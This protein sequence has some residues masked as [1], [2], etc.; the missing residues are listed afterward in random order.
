MLLFGSPAAG[1]ACA[2]HRPAHASG[3]VSSRPPGTAGAA[4]EFLNGLQALSADDAWAV[5]SSCLPRCGRHASS[6]RTLIEHWNGASW[7]VVASPDPSPAFSVLTAVAASSAG[8]AWAVGSYCRSRCASTSSAKGTLILHWNGRTWAKVASPDP[9]HYSQLQGV[10]ARSAS[11]AWAVGFYYGRRDNGPR[12]LILHWN[13]RT[14]AKLPSPGPGAVLNWLESV[15]AIS[16]RNAW[17]AGY[18]GTADY[19]PQPLVLH[20]NGRTWTRQRIPNPHRFFRTLSGAAAVSGTDVLAVGSFSASGCGTRDRSYVP[21]WNAMALRWDGESWAAV[22]TP[23]PDGRTAGLA[24]VAGISAS[25]AW[26]VGGFRAVRCG[27]PLPADDT[28]ILRWDGH[29]WTRVTSPDPST[30]GNELAGVSAVSADDA[31]AVGDR[32]VSCRSGSPV[33]RPLILHWNGRAWSV[34]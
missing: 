15:S 17:A 7:S 28:L 3:A 32:S 14:W 8:N 33:L 5:G 10:A 9:G 19:G 6:L 21:H 1:L 22:A 23:T 25:D 13:G 11:D 20:W 31:W 24:A 34:R 12:T 18:T 27:N 4:D 29:T 30:C 26:A 16:A 2:A